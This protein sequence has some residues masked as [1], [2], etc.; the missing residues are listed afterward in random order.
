MITNDSAI[1]VYSAAY[2][3]YR[4]IQKTWVNTYD[5]KL[6]FSGKERDNDSGLDYFG[7][8]Y[9][10]HSNYRFISVDPVINREEAISNRS[11]GTCIPA[12]GTMCA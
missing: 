1:V 10:N 3:P 12:A 9:H 8:R 7:A 2:D 6:K 5:P 11:C 4:G